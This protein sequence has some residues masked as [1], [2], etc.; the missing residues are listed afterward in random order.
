MTQTIT[1]IVGD[2]VV[3]VGLVVNYL[4]SHKIETIVTTQPTPP[5]TTTTKS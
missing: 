5:T 3:I 1:T 2:V 4:K